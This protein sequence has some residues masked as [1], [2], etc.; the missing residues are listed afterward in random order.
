MKIFLCLVSSDKS[1]S[2]VYSES[3]L[4]LIP[5]H[6]L[7][8]FNFATF[9]F[10]VFDP[11]TNN[12]GFE[13]FIKSKLDQYQSI[14]IIL[15][16]HHAH[17]V[18]D[19]KQALFI[20]IPEDPYNTKYDN[21]FTKILTQAL[22][23]YCNLLNVMRDAAN[24]KALILPIRN[25]DACELRTLTDEFVTKTLKGDF[26]DW[27]GRLLTEL[28]KRKSPKRN[29]PHRKNFFKDD[30]GHYFEYGYENHSRFETGPPHKYSCEINGVFRFGK[31]IENIQR[32]FNV[33]KDTTSK[34]N[35]EFYNC[36]N[37]I[38]NIPTTSHIN[39]F[40]NDFV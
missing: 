22:K 8:K 13:A 16:Q 7:E 2:D 17:V 38:T 26:G 19:I 31:R 6:I 29:N 37:E 34:I 25:F 15:Q 4:K 36:H 21:Y 3:K 12:V 1:A 20:V 5:A 33:T 32:H 30:Q 24:E 9:A 10:G 35:G 40:C 18:Q 39:M 14:V 28:K 23:N 27:L 11:A